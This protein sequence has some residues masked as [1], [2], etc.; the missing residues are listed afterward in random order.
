MVKIGKMR[1]LYLIVFLTSSVFGVSSLELAQNI[2]ADSS[3]KRQIDLL[4][5]HQELNDNKGNLD[6]ERISRILKTNSLLNLTLPSPQTLRLNFK[7]KSDAV[8]FFKIINEAL[9]E[10]GY[11]YF[12]P[13]HLNLS[14]GEI[15]YT[16]QVESQY[17]LDPGT[18]YRILRAN[19]V[20][21]EDIR[22]SAKNYY[23]Y[24]LDFSEARL[25]TNVN[26]ALNVT[27]NLEKPLRDYV[28]ALKGAKSISIE[29][30]AAES[31][32]AK[33]LFLDKN[34]NLISAIKNDKK[35]NSFSGSIP[36]GAVYA[37]VSDMY[38]LDNIKR[39][40]KITLKR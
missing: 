36:S 32:F 24:E 12:I 27:K 15:D 34:L 18:F 14:K 29:A 37:I 31:W 28:F 3:K 13:V 11:V 6:I 38:N 8:L 4:F 16:I 33:I 25:E 7:A 17:V 5:A 2:V 19:S 40:L 20:Y 21:I 30:N 10:A 26:L 22:Q 39:G 1:F 35:N 23:E 9:N